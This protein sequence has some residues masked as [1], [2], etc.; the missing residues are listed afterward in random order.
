MSDPVGPQAAP[1][2]ASVDAL[3]DVLD[4]IH[5]RGEALTSVRAGGGTE[6]R[7]APGERALHLVEEGPVELVVDEGTQLRLGRGDMALLAT[8]APHWLRAVEGDA[9]WMSGR[10]LVEESAASPLLASL[11]EVI[12]L[13]GSEPGLERLPLSAGLLAAEIAD[14]SAESRAMASRLLDLLFIKALRAWSDADGAGG[15]PGWL[16]AALDRSL[17]PAL[18]AIH[19][20]PEQP[21]TVEELAG[22]ASLSRAAFAARFTRLAGDPPARY[23]ARLRLARAADRIATTTEPVGAIGKALG[24]ESEAAFSRAFT[25]E[26]GTAPRDWRATRRAPE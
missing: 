11:P 16:T 10:F 2:D 21:W 9:S 8:G 7:H 20:H 17:G 25:R 24:Y 13:R 15:S 1:L 26:Y 6:V 23:L 3:S 14:P 5:L 22:L 18:W 4:M 19:R 12:V